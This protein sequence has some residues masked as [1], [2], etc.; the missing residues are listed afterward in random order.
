MSKFLHLMADRHIDKQVQPNLFG[1]SQLCVLMPGLSSHS[2]GMDWVMHLF[3][4]CCTSRFGVF[5]A[6]TAA[7]DG[8][9]FL[10]ETF[11]PGIFAFATRRELCPIYAKI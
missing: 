9:G 11:L 1:A 5:F 7:E 6:S 10:L 4:T 3:L 2:K 8:F